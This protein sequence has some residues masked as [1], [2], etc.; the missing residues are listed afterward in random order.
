M[1]ECGGWVRA[2]ASGR[3]CGL[4]L[5]GTGAAAIAAV[6]IAGLLK[7]PC[8]GVWTEQAQGRWLCYNDITSLYINRGMTFP[9]APYHSYAFEYPAL[10]AMFAY[11]AAALAAGYGH[12]AIGAHL[13][14]ASTAAAYYVVS[15]TGLAACALAVVYCVDQLAAPRRRAAIV[16]LA[17]PSLALAAF[18][19]WDLLAVALATAAMLAWQRHNPAMA[20]LLIGL[21]AAAKLYP[22]LLLFPILLI[23]IRTRELRTWATVT[24]SAVTAWVAVNAPFVLAPGYRRGW[25]LFYTFS[26]SRHADRGTLWFILE[27]LGL[28]WAGK[29]SAQNVGYALLFA[30]CLAM[31]AVLAIR[32]ARPPEL[33]D[34]ALLT[35]AAF[36]LTGKAWSP[37]Y[38][39]WLLPLVVLSVRSRPAIIAWA[40]AELAYFVA[41]NWFALQPFPAPLRISTGTFT[42]ICI[43]RWLA[44]AMVCGVGLR[45][46]LRGE[47][48]TDAR[49]LPGRWAIRSLAQAWRAG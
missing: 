19:N 31:I 12:L 46:I 15:M 14:A 1:A 16:M 11:A 6:I 7:A 41:I 33:A 42:L 36:L 17:I 9:A 25:T 24:L 22:V 26:A 20:G 35:I 5:V 37:Q 4:W 3:H 48:V 40:A 13:T 49:R 44:L 23:C 10:T 28:R 21:G 43:V 30:A 8:V 27:N 45:R 32:A 39:L 2:T 47:T 34:L 29:L 18:I 38:V